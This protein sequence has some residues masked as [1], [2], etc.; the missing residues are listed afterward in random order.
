MLHVARLFTHS[1]KT[2]RCDSKTRVWRLQTANGRLL[3]GA[4]TEIF[5]FPFV[6]SS[7]SKE[8]QV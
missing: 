7:Q 4:I 6:Y 8:F 5:Y 1:V 2:W 3:S